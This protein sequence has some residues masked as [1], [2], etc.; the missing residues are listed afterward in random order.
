M[1]RV[2]LLT[3]MYPPHHLGGY[4][5]SCRDVV[6]R[7]R[8]RG[9]RVDV[10]TTSTRIAGAAALDDEADGVRRELELYWR[11]YQSL[12]PSLRA[13]IRME[14]HNQRCLMRAIEE[15]R[16]DVI[17]LWHMGAMSMGLIQTLTELDR[18]IVLVVCDDWLV[19]G[20]EADPWM[21]MFAGRPRLGA[22]A[23]R[24]TGLPT[25]VAFDPNAV[26][27][28][29]VSESVRN[30]ASET[31]AIKAPRTT[32]VQSGIELDEFPLIERREPWSWRLLAVGRLEE[33][34]GIHIA[35]EAMT[36][37]PDNAQLD[38]VG[39]ARA[40]YLER[41]HRR[42]ER[43]G[44]SDRVR[45]VG[46]VER[47]ALAEHYR[48]ADAFLFPTQ[49]EEPFGLVPLESMA[50]GTPV[51]ATG[52]GGSREFLFDRVNCLLTPPGDAERLADAVKVLADD[53]SLRE[54]LFRAG[55]VTA[56]HF[57]VD[58]LARV[59]EAW[60][61]AAADRFQTDIPPSQPD[62]ADILSRL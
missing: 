25:T 56:E 52:T 16:P 32:V 33:R 48:S 20:I 31:P 43:L 29:F 5:L 24:A 28:C 49:W 6:Q 19:Y 44:L 3:N 60:H 2:L 36:H 4:E 40:S 23:R 1:L 53:A 42:T 46:P 59:L 50:C 62:I 13:R 51:V 15:T 61:V 37:L 30:R 11:E 7:W 57:T 58:R 18:P 22:L 26:A 47:S 39:P 55:R 17:S 45:F 12:K 41:L 14:R 9:H 34:K 38:V 27:T 35:I 8:A 21:N 54:S 10:L